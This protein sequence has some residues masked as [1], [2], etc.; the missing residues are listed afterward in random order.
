MDNWNYSCSC[1]LGDNWKKFVNLEAMQNCSS[2]NEQMFDYNDS[3]WRLL[4][5]MLLPTV[6]S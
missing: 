3:I 6:P 4:D 1:K 5:W 2:C